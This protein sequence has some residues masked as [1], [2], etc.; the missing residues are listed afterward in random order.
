[1]E[2]LFT[3]EECKELIE[4]AEAKNSW[5]RVDFDPIKSKYSYI[6]L[7]DG[8]PFRLKIKE[9]I[10]D[11]LNY[12]TKNPGIKILKYIIGDGLI[13]HTDR[14]PSTEYNKDFLYNVNVLLND[15][16][17]GGEFLLNDEQIT[18]NHVG[19][20]YYYRSTVPHEVKPVT[21]GTRY[22]AIFYLRERD[23]IKHKTNII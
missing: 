11:N 1:M 6:D 3:R 14:S 12:I 23:I 16:F 4:F 13:R 20:I 2:S 19:N 18:N 21:K 17:E 9:Y 8:H 22:S 10:E 15:D 7:D 5:I